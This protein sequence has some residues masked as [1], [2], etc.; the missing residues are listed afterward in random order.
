MRISLFFRWDPKKAVPDLCRQ[1]V[2]QRGV[3]NDGVWFDTK[4]P[5]RGQGGMSE[6]Y[7][8]SAFRYFLKEFD[9]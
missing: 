8:L 2:P 4:E 1:T 5:E 3:V 7:E 6:K 9:L